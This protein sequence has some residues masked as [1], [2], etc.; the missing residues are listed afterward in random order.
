MVSSCLGKRAG[1][2]LTLR[3]RQRWQP[4]FNALYQ[5]EMVFLTVSPWHCCRGRP[6]I[7]STHILQGI[8]TDQAI[9]RISCDLLFLVLGHICFCRTSTSISWLDCGILSA[10]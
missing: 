4:L 8:C 1:Q 7:L 9:L 3:H 6:G 2:K 5:S 10:Y